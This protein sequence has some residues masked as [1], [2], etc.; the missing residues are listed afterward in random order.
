MTSLFKSRPDAPWYGYLPML[1]VVVFFTLM[2]LEDEGILGVLH[3][4]ILSVLLV[5][6]IR[7]RTL[8][9]WGLMLILCLAYGVAV[10]LTPDWHN[11]GEW[12]FFVACGFIP[13]AV[14]FIGRP[15]GTFRDSREPTK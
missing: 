4:I 12:L 14:L 9:G 11:K 15:P 3:F 1:M 8:A 10:L 5:L 7:Y 2:G 13:A 6:Q